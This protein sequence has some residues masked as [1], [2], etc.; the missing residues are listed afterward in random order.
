MFVSLLP[1]KMR[2][3]WLRKYAADLRNP[4][5][6]SG[7]AQMLGC[8]SAL[9]VGYKP[10]VQSQFAAIDH[11]VAVGGAETAGETAVMG[12]GLILA[13]AYILRPLSVALLYFSIEGA[14]RLV[15]AVAGGESI[16]TLPLYLLC[17]LERKTKKEVHEFKL[18]ARIRD[19]VFPAPDGEPEYDLVIASC[20][21]KDWNQSLTISHEGRLYE[22]VRWFEAD[23]PRR[24]VY[25]LKKAPLSKLVR[26]LHQYDP[27]EGITAES[28]SEL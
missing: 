7:I 12:F 22:L 5:I 18:G 14:V 8:L 17:L 21:P 9:I 26:G 1:P 11:R 10:F 13:L 16:G 4:A 15:A 3:E 27:D 23:P 6:L 19:K 2:P 20:R 24:F 25:L 28:V